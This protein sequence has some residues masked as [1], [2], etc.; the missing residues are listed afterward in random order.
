MIR[1]VTDFLKMN[2]VEYI[3]DAQLS[4]ISPIRIGG[5]A[6]LI[7]YPNSEKR[8]VSLVQF[9]EKSKFNYKIVGRMSN[10]LPPDEKYEGILIRTDRINNLLVNNNFLDAFLG[11]SMHKTAKILCDAG[12]SGFEG[13][14]GIPG[15]IGGGTLGNAGAFGREISDL[16]QYVRAYDIES[17]EIIRLS[18]SQCD[19]SYRNSVFKRCKIIIL[20][21]GLVLSYSDTVKVAAEMKRIGDIR[22]NTQPVDK[23]SLGSTFKRPTPD[24]S[25]A[26]L[27]DSCDL[28]GHKVGGAKVSEKHAGFIINAGG[29][30]ADDYLRLC[31]DVAMR[32]KE[33]YGIL[34]HREVE[35]M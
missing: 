20:S 26:K 17:D 24:I 7:A 13:L 9:L 29:A 21:V 28:K 30:T 5:K 1:E 23:P 34:L 2:D 33:S 18:S 19:F 3:E 31:D 32:V 35:I 22:R 4:E 12:L 16:V 14:S 27:I 8:F 15:S 11:A 6:A 25:A 10:L